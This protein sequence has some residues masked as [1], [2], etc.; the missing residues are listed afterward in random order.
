[1]AWN[2]TA[3]TLFDE[4]AVTAVSAPPPDGVGLLTTLQFVPFQCSINV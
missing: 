2:P 1:L 4:T 3:Q